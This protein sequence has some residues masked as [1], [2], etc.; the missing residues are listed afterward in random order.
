MHFF[1]LYLCRYFCLILSVSDYPVLKR[2]N[3]Q[4]LAKM[5]VRDFLLLYMSFILSSSFFYQFHLA[6][7]PLRLLC[8]VVQQLRPCFLLMPDI[9]VG[10]G[11]TRSNGCNKLGMLLDIFVTIQNLHFLACDVSTVQWFP[12]KKG[13]F[14]GCMESKGTQNT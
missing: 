4:T 5:W 1:T 3:D 12:C 8:A 10:S 14:T 13:T 2:Q 9:G 6:H 7:F 11:K